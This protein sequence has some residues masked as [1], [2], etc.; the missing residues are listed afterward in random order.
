MNLNFQI[1]DNSFHELLIE[2]KYDKYEIL[3]QYNLSQI[4]A[5]FECQSSKV[6]DNIVDP[7]F[8]E[9]NKNKWRKKCMKFEHI[10]NQ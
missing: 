8:E 7:F 9:K 4:Q 2:K 6:W 10:M 1:D 5:T 3:E